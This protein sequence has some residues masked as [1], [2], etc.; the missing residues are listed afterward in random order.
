MAIDV[1][2]T[3]RL[4]VGR[5]L[6]NTEVDSN[7]RKLATAASTLEQNQG[8]GG[9]PTNAINAAMQ[10][11]VDAE[12]PHAQY[13]RPPVSDSKVYSMKNGEWIEAGGYGRVNFHV[14]TNMEFLPDYFV[15][16]D[17]AGF[18]IENLQHAPAGTPSQ[19]VIAS[20]FVNTMAGL[21]DDVSGGINGDGHLIGIFNIGMINSNVSLMLGH[22]FRLEMRTGYT[23]DQYVAVKHVVGPTAQFGGTIKKYVLEQLDDM[24]ASV[25]NVQS[26]E[27]NLLDPRLVTTD[28]GGNIRPGGD[29]ITASFRLTN[30]HS[31][32][33][34]MINSK[35]EV[36]VTIGEEV[37]DGFYVHLLQAGTGK[38]TLAPDWAFHAYF[39]KGNRVSTVAQLDTVEITCYRFGPV[40]AEFKV[41]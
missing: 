15:V 8:V 17:S 34:L 27:R 10:R 2:L 39:A 5:K 30:K 22:E 11:H 31:G 32:K 6:T 21:N 41:G 24:R 9:D 25:T 12:N 33:R 14:S 19:A 36:V 23:I 13:L 37:T 16:K 4:D 38:I 18:V 26:F 29:A 7:F 40:L 28:V 35:A 20:M 3:Y 1:Q